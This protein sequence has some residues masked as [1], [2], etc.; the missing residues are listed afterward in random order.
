MVNVM[1]TSNE[2]RQKRSIAEMDENDYFFLS[3]SKHLQKLP[4]TDQA[5]IKFQLHK[6][7]HESEKKLLNMF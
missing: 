1:K 3:M 4:K 7:I 5:E 6:M 2:L